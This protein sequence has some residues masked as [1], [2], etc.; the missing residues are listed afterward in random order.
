MKLPL[1][2]PGP[3][4]A[5]TGV[6]LI[7]LALLVDWSTNWVRAMLIAPGILATAL[8]SPALRHRLRILLDRSVDQEASANARLSSHSSL[9]VVY[10]IWCALVLS[11]VEGAFWTFEKVSGHEVVGLRYLWNLPLGYLLIFGC[12]GLLMTIAAQRLPAHRAFSWMIGTSALIVFSAILF[13]AGRLHHAA[14]GLLAGGLAVQVAKRSRRHAHLFHL[15]VGWTAPWLAL[16][17]VGSAAVSVAWRYRTEQAA[18]AALPPAVEGQPSILLITLD[19]VRAQSMSL[20][21]YSRATTPNIDRFAARGVVFDSALSTAP[22]TLPSHASLFTGRYPHELTAGYTTALDAT[23]PTIA[24]VLQRHGY[25]TAAFVANDV[26]GPAEFGLARG[27]IHYEDVRSS[28]TAVLKATSLGKTLLS[29]LDLESRFG[30]HDTF[31]LKSAEQV[32]DDFLTWLEGR[33]DKRPFFAFLNYF[34][35][36]DPYFSPSQFGTMFSPTQPR[37]DLQSRPLNEWS[38]TDIR[39][40]NDAYDGAIAYLDHRLGVLL[41]ELEDR[42]LLE[43]TIVVITSDHGEHFGEHGLLLHGAS[44]YRPVL[45][46]PLLVVYQGLVPAGGRV[47]STVS[48]RDVSATVLDLAGLARATELPGRSLAPSWTESRPVLPSDNLPVF[49]EVEQAAWSPEGY[50]ARTGSLESVVFGQF[51]YIRNNGSGREELYD[52]SADAEQAVDLSTERPEKVNELR[53]LM[54]DF[55]NTPTP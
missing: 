19:T 46:V 42:R 27:F 24:E 52:V 26:Y 8:S 11:F 7:A 41:Q 29:D 3:A 9:F 49:S 21:G 22:W 13:L 5:G 38:S 50:P 31:G 40:L 6:V 36:H 15:L 17:V 51:Q 20:Y 23:Y 45:H 43:N 12:V 14:V 16:V 28:P 18:V 1:R 55:R 34:D 32:G 2:A 37:G 33:D 10:G 53:R 30:G 35:A 47:P 39:E 54:H 25:M 44:L 48:L 4:L